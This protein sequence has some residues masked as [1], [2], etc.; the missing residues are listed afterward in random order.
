MI[1]FSETFQ[2]QFSQENSDENSKEKKNKNYKKQIKIRRIDFLCKNL[3]E[4]QNKILCK[5][6]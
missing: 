3:S 5:H 1:A 4:N 2:K 6:S